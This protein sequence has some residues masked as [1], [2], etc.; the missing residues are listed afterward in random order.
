MIKSFMMYVCK[1]YLLLFAWTV[2]VYHP[3]TGR[4]IMD[5]LIYLTLD[6]CQMV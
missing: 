4:L 3:T 2:P 5:Y 6:A 1:I